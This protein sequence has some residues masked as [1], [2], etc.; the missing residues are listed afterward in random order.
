MGEKILHQARLNKMLEDKLLISEEPKTPRD[1]DL[2]EEDKDPELRKSL[3]LQFLNQHQS[4]AQ[5]KCEA[6][7]R[8][9][10]ALR[11]ENHQLL[12]NKQRKNPPG[13]LSVTGTKVLNIAEMKTTKKGSRQQLDV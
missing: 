1:N 10:N 2:A 5:L 11:H 8:R 3:E 6:L 7:R 4:L 9:R 12:L 13:A